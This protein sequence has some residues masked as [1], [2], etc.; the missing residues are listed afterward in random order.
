MRILL[1]TML[2]LLLTAGGVYAWFYYGGFGGDKG[3]AVAFIDAYSTYG[4]TAARVEALVH[5]PSTANNGSRGELNGLLETILTEDVTVGRRDTLARL[6]FKHLAVLRDEVDAAQ[7]AQ[8]ALYE[9]LQVMDDVLAQ[10]DGGQMRAQGQEIVVAARKRAELTARITS[11][12][13]ETND[14]T[15]NIITRILGE[16]GE[17]TD[18]HIV[19][20]NESTEKAEGRHATLTRLYEELAQQQAQVEVMFTLFVDSAL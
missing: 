6:A 9:H 13:S 20:I 2:L 5:Q 8:A 11:V 17:L 1:G 4:E 19:A 3:E 14:Q 10:I 18:E 16:G 7:S 15:E 12:L